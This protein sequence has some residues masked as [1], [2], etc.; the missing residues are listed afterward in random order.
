MA[1]YP[2]GFYGILYVGQNA[3]I[4]TVSRIEAREVW[5]MVRYWRKFPY[6][7]YRYYPKADTMYMLQCSYDFF[8]YGDKDVRDNILFRMMVDDCRTRY[9]NEVKDEIQ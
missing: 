4:Y 1:R 9:W 8:M 3:S 7:L 2:K 5:K 6:A